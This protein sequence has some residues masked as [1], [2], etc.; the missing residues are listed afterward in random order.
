MIVRPGIEVRAPQTLDISG[1]LSFDAPGLSTQVSAGGVAI[2]LR[3][4]GD[5]RVENTVQTGFSSSQAAPAGLPAAGSAGALRVVAGADLASADVLT[6]VRGAAGAVRLGAASVALADPSAVQLRS[7]TGAVDVVAASDIVLAHRRAAITTTGRVADATPGQP[8]LAGALVD[9]VPADNEQSAL[10]PFLAHG[11]RV[12]VQA[13]RD[14]I[15]TAPNAD[16]PYITDWWWRSGDGFSFGLWWSRFDLFGSGIA[17]FGGSD[18]QISA[19]RDATALVA[20]APGSGWVN[21]GN[22]ARF[23]GGSVSVQAGRDVIGGQWF[24]SGPALDLRAGGRIGAA[25]NATPAAPAAATTAPQLVHQGTAVRVQARGDVALASVRSAGLAAPVVANSSATETALLSL[26][27][28][29][30]LAVASTAGSVSLQNLAQPTAPGSGLAAGWSVLGSVIPASATLAAPSGALRLTGNAVQQPT[31]ASTDSSSAPAAR[32]DLV[33]ETSV[34]IG[35]ITVN[36]SDGAAQPRARELVVA[37]EQQ[38]ARRN[39]DGERLDATA[40][41]PVRVVSAAGDVELTGTLASARPV[42]V[43]AARDI[44]F[45]GSGNVA[46]QHQSATP[47]VGSGGST[48]GAE[49]SLFEAGRDISTRGA[50]AAAGIEAGGP[51]D[52][53]L[54]AGRNV[55]L[56]VG[57]GLVSVGNQRASTLLPETGAHII[58]IAGLAAAAGSDLARAVDNGYAALGYRTLT[59]RPGELYAGLA[60]SAPA[61]TVAG[62]NALP[63]DERLR[64]ASTLLGDGAAAARQRF[65]TTVPA[66]RGLTADA[67]AQQL[68][69]AEPALKER[70]VGAL[71]AFALEQAGVTLR[72]QVLSTQLQRHG[73]PYLAGLLAHLA[74]QTGRVHNSSEALASF[75]ALPRAQQL[76]WLTQVL[77]SELRAAGRDAAQ[78]AGSEREAGYAAGYLALD[79]LF[80][81]VRPSG[82]IALPTSQVK[83]VQPA[84]IVLLAPGGGINAGEVTGSTPKKANELGIVTVAGGGIFAAA[85][86]SFDVNQSRVFTLRKGDVLLWSSDGNIDA[87]RGAKT[88][89][90]APA[91][92]LRLDEEGRLVLDT[93]GSFSG[94]GIAVLDSTS[95]LDLYAPRGEINAGEAGIKSLGNAFFGA[96]RFVGADNLAVGG[97]SVGAPPAAPSGGSTAG[98]AALG[99]SATAA[100]P[101]PAAKKDDEDE[102]K[103]RRARRNVFLDFLGFSQGE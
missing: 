22:L 9:F 76:P 54:L 64:L 2:T 21:A 62:F 48:S 61:V 24:A 7:S 56:G 12:R 84:R 31:V 86:D 100:G 34:R 25:A 18:V 87:G 77:E 82:Q 102:R 68:Q 101:Q 70:A 91:P 15:G 83:T 57:T 58:V 78:K 14:V 98:L 17:T 85:R 53:V 89:S 65:V 63:V 3:A 75:A 51:G 5:V 88:V 40:R 69:D 52:L 47:R 66:W 8:D 80:P 81:G 74:Q 38:I 27:M 35:S 49:S 103:K 73:S 72:D 90:G 94:S 10:S 19:G 37:A 59:A 32:L 44:V 95:A 29:A 41:A 20:A 55:D 4:A 60:S 11:G 30:A 67:A 39:V 99:Q 92:V 36:A 6:T 1:T 33:A 45:D 28:D 26:D 23:G 96:V 71:L 93:S 97:I 43:K 13:G 42:Q 50:S 46:L 79:A 16:T